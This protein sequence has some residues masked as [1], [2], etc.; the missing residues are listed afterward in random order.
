MKLIV[1]TLLL[2]LC[3]LQCSYSQSQSNLYDTEELRVVDDADLRTRLFINTHFDRSLMPF[4]MGWNFGD[5]RTRHGNDVFD[6]IEHYR[7][8]RYRTNESSVEMLPACP[9]PNDLNQFID[10]NEGMVMLMINASLLRR[11]NSSDR[12]LQ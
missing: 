9:L 2:V 1:A 7:T 3:E 8:W 4:T 12:Q 11:E 10:P 5:L 6:S